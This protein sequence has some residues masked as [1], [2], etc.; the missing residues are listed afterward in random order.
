MD[1][2]ESIVSHY[3]LRHHLMDKPGEK[4]SDKPDGKR[5][6]APQKLYIVALSGGADSVAL[7]LI[8]RAIGIRVHAAHCN[9]HLRGEESDRDE[10]FCADLCQRLDVPLHRIHFDTQ[11]Y[12][13][14]HKVSIEMAARELRY[15]YFAQLARDICAEGICVAHHKDDNVETLLL[16]LLR[17]SGVD[18][19][20][21]IAPKNGNILRPLLCI[22]RKQILAYLKEKGQAYVTDSTNLEDDALR[23]KIRHHVIPLLE[24]L[25]PAARENIAQTARYIRQAKQTIDNILGEADEADSAETQ[26]RQASAEA[27][28]REASP[29]P[30]VI[31][32]KQKMLQAASPEFILHHLIGK[33]GF[34]GEQIDQIVEAIGS[35]AEDNEPRAKAAQT[36]AK[37]AQTSIGKTWQSNDHL[38]CIDRTQLI[39]TSLQRMEHLS[40][41]RPHRLPEEGIYTLGS[42]EN[43]YKETSQSPGTGSEENFYKYKETSQ[44][45]GTGTAEELR[46]RIARHPRT[47]GF[48]PS[49]DPM[50]ITLDADKVRF[51]LTYRLAHPGDRF[52]PFGMRGSKLVSDYLTDRKRNFLQ[53]KSQHVLADREGNIIWLV[54]ERTSDDCKIS[55]ETQ[56]IIEISLGE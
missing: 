55:P 22:D 35:N 16:N 20:A 6:D 34:H 8:L 11:A 13:Q 40:Q 26:N 2:T 42:A 19:L 47:A 18:G 12:A 29:E 41:E 46:I 50:R 48:K 44:S 9:F 23:N 45:P 30:F 1:K 36:R 25:N 54:G 17:G 37:A 53:K 56:E 38:L 21:A 15:R 33:Y 14:L 10:Q 3:I 5:G 7:L 43:F 39:I 31:I 49:K 27:R 28:N 51:P 32:E 4:P 52:H 24:S